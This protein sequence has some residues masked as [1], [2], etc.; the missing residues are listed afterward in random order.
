[1][2]AV[3]SFL[4][5]RELLQFATLKILIFWTFWDSFGWVGLVWAG[6]FLF[7]SGEAWESE[8]ICVFT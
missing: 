7:F 3:P 6:S 8:L 5:V 2:T 1:M 4:R